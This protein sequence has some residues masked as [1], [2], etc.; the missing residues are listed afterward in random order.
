VTARSPSGVLPVEKGPGVTSF[1]V[2]A[3][4]RRALRASRVGHGGTLDPQATGVLPI[5]IGEAT[6]LTPYLTELDKEYVATVRLG[7]VTAT[8]DMTG[9]VLE[10][11]PVP[12][13][14][15]QAIEGALRRF[16]GVISQVPPMYSA[17]HRD[18]RRLYELAR[19]G[20]TV[21]R[22]ARQV[23]VHSITLE[24]LNLPE[25]TIRIRCGK[26]TYVRTL[27]A[28]LGALLGCGG[29]LAALI[30]TR[31]GPYTLADAVPWAELCEEGRAASLWDRL[32]P[33]DS[34]LVSLPPVRLDDAR[35]LRFVHGQAVPVAGGAEGRVRVYAPDGRC[36]DCEAR[37]GDP[38][39]SCAAWR[40]SRL[41]SRRR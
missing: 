9:P 17:L 37:T 5:L 1:Q 19:E 18:G 16:V 6:K 36:L 3:R 21:E 26:G 28:D 24:G 35:A 10:T 33:V 8:E 7:V 25:L 22:E 41:T 15:A 2:V 20:R 13:L 12:P 30:R 32:Y 11:R 23:T 39:G 38:C 4:L 14:D 34:A 29:A 40:P 27:S 31:V